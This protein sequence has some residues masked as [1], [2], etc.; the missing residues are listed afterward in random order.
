MPEENL[1]ENIKKAIAYIEELDKSY[2]SSKDKGDKNYKKTY[3]K[4]Y[5]EAITTK[6]AFA[7]VNDLGERY[8]RIAARIILA[9][10]EPGD[11]FR[12]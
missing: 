6:F 5:E 7:L 12:Y 1:F 4:D 11:L 10:H 9:I 2:D 8:A 3:E